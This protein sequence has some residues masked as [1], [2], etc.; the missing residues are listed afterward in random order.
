MEPRAKI[1]VVEDDESQR[2]LYAEELRQGR[3]I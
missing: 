1:L 2:F 3:I